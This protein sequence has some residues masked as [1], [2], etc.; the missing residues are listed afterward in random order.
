MI[1]IKTKKAFNRNINLV[2]LDKHIIYIRKF[3]YNLNVPR[4]FCELSK[5][6]KEKECKLERNYLV[7]DETNDLQL[8]WSSLVLPRIFLQTCCNNRLIEF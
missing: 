8:N 7:G 5:N 3:Y 4:N 6:Q 1:G 2:I